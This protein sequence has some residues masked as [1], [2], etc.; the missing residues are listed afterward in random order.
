MRDPNDDLVRGFARACRRGD[1]AALR[2]TLAADVI[3][4]SDSGGRL[5]ALPGLVRG[6][7]DVARLAAALLGESGLL[8]GSG[9]MSGPGSLDEPGEP[10]EPGD[11]E[12]STE[13]VN[14]RAGLALRRTGR[15]VAVVGI[16]GTAAGI[17]ALWIVLNP[18]KLGGWHR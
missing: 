4:V 7:Q 1:V 15:A 14:G 3:A 12:L 16:D 11:A 5:P 9:S 18:D 8:W 10:G 6:A 17:T 13:V 2:A